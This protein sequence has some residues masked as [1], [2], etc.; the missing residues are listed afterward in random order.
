MVPLTASVAQGSVQPPG[1]ATN[2]MAHIPVTRGGRE[3]AAEA[4]VGLRGFLPRSC[5]RPLVLR[6][7]PEEGRPG[8]MGRLPLQSGGQQRLVEPATPEDRRLR[9]ALMLGKEPPGLPVSPR[10]DP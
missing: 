6:T 9:F 10:Q 1:H 5:C 8:E 2:G 3:G 4:T 7:S